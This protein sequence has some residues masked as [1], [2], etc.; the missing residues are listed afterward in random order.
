[1]VPNVAREVGT[2]RVNR[3]EE[4]ST[5]CA[6]NW[7][8][9]CRVSHS[10]DSFLVA[11]LARTQFS[12]ALLFV[13]VVVSTADK[14]AGNEENTPAE[15]VEHGVEEWW[16]PTLVNLIHHPRVEILR[17]SGW[18]AACDLVRGDPAATSSTAVAAARFVTAALQIGEVAVDLTPQA[19]GAVSVVRRRLQ[20]YSTGIDGPNG[21]ENEKDD[22]GDHH[23]GSR[24]WSLPRAPLGPRRGARDRRNGRVRRTSR[25]DC[26]DEHV[27]HIHD[28]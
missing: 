4:T 16:H 13:S 15:E 24:S 10:T 17:E 5:R 18:Q 11:S 20:I 25:D 23:E 9:V 2:L 8:V 26:G 6:V 22:Q 1:M 14:G 7:T 12:Q 21:D 19:R 28:R 27:E 3:V